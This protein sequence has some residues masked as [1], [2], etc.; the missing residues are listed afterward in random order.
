[1]S[2]FILIAEGETPTPKTG[3]Q[4]DVG[5]F[6]GG[7]MFW[8]LGA[9]LLFWL[10]VMLPAERRRRREAASLLASIKP[11]SKIVTTAG[12]VGTVVNS[13]D[14]E[15]EITIRSAESKMKVLR[16][17]VLRVLGEEA[18]ESK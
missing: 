11:G 18:V 10:V 4:Q 12:I 7:I 14:G 3:P 2:S 6:G 17:S 13:K 1:M 9:F 15:D 5:P 16:S 8:M